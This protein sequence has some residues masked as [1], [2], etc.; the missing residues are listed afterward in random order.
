MFLMGVHSRV[1]VQHGRLDE[2][3]RRL[4]AMCNDGV[5][6]TAEIFEVRACVVVVVAV[7]S[8]A[9]PQAHPPHPIPSRAGRERSRGGPVPL[10]C[11][12]APR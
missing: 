6:P 8:S 9:A 11:L 3:Q 4:A 1:Q 12:V 10:R 2:A 5:Q 7:V